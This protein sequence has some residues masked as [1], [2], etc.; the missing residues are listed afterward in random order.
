[1]SA[2]Q[3]E[4]STILMDKVADWLNQSALAGHDLETLIKGFC[5]RLAAAGLPLKR[6]HLSFSMLHPLYDALGFTWFRGE[7]IEVESFRS[8]PGVLSD[9]FAT[10]PYYH[11]LSNKLDHLRRRL[12]TSMP[13]EFPV[14][15]DLRLMGVTDYMAF[16]LPFSGNTSQGMMGSWSTDSAAG[17]SDSM[18]SALLRI[19]SH[20]AIATKMAV[21]TK[22]ADNMMTTYL[23]GDA[24]RRVLDGQIKRGEGDTIRAAL[25]MGDMRGSSKLAETSGREIYID[26]LNQF[27]DAVAAPFNRK[28]GQIMSFIGDGFIA[29]YPCERHRS[30]SEIACQAALA[31]AHKATARMMD[32]NLHRKE[33]GLS[34]IKFGIGLH[35][36]NVMFGNVGLTDRLTFSVFGSAV[37]EVQ[38]LQTLTKKY[39][40]SV[41]ASK[42]FA[43]YCGANSWLT[44]G[45][46]ELIGI[47]QKLTVL[48]PD[49]SGT[50]GLDEDGALEPT[51]GRISD[52][53]QVML[54][55]REAAR[56][57]AG[58]PRKIQ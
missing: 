38:R 26:T 30:Q 53:E 49:L 52:A 39:P 48:S 23:G 13:S 19:Q 17:F 42:D 5:E 41:L 33:K 29:V 10:S 58:D 20:L 46:E 35:V 55:H 14:F 15:D 44:L 22:L 43:S 12:D 45:N 32:L 8:K 37:N 24:G 7:G 36:G 21:L 3:A 16:V 50:L 51:H 9:R 27:F 1:M 28:G 47:K 57:A 2:A 40:H 34:D 54:L 18:I 56:M 31:A 6:V 4:I 11:L 25:V